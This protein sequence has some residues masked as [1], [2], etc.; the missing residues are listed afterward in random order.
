MTAI[1]GMLGLVLSLLHG[2]VGYNL[3]ILFDLVPSHTV[4]KDGNSLIISVIN[5][6]FWAIT[7]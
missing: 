3:A 2:F 5:G 4:I 7:Y 6:A 1:F